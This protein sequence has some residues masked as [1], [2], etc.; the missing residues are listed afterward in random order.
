MDVQLVERA[1]EAIGRF[2]LLSGG[3]AVLVAVSGGQ[4]SV[5]LF[6]V[7]R[8]LAPAMRL[9][10]AIA[11]LHHGLRGA[12]ADGDEALVRRLA[13]S[14]GAAFRAR[15]LD[16]PALARESGRS[17]EE[18]GR[19]ARYE[20]FESV[21]REL[22]ADVVALGHTASDRAETLLM[23]LLRG[24]GL[25]GLGSIP[26][27][28]GHIVRPLILATREETLA[29][30]RRKGLELA[31]DRTNLAP[32]HLR[33]K[34]RL[35]LLPLLERKYVRGAAAHIARAAELA[36]EEA[37]LLGEL[38]L[39]A[40]S[41]ASVESGPGHITLDLGAVGSMPEGLARRVLREAIRATSGDV[42][43]LQYNHVRD[44]MRLIKGGRTGAS[45]GLPGGVTVE[46]TY[47]EVRIARHRAVEP[48][49]GSVEVRLPLAGEVA[50]PAL[51]VRVRSE[52]HDGKPEALPRGKSQATVDA[53]AAG[54]AL[55]VRNWRPGDRFCPL[56]L[57]GEKKLQDFF[58]DAKVP[59]AERTRVPIVARADGRII[60]VVGHRLDEQAKVLASTSR[61]LVLTASPL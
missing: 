15:R 14:A 6:D 7:L 23:N 51:G 35:E 12:E 20:F 61:V 54:E 59:R 47:G 49:P 37:Q 31:V 53:N 33:N 52:V 2:G 45:L 30:C 29:H 41:E 55:V 8:Q 1:E 50:V 44:I 24:T 56:G 9:R 60:W 46:R 26:P 22:G 42:R 27:K 16:V 11:H 34:V 21:R 48:S 38:A 18:A 5:A 58:V 3:E 4:D 39:Q 10:L 13:E 57:G 40:L 28:R 19:E 25:D 43:D 32:G 17:F 36:H